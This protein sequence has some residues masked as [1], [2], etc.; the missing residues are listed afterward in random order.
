MQG[1]CKSLHSNIREPLNSE[2]RFR[3]VASLIF[4]AARR[5]RGNKDRQLSSRR[6][7]YFLQHT[8]DVLPDSILRHFKAAPDLLIG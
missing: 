4:D 7:T 3:H 2:F 1:L 6:R 8:R 5:L